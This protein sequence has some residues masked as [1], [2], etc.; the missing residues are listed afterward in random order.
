MAELGSEP[1]CGALFGRE[2]DLREPRFRVTQFS[3]PSSVWFISVIRSGNRQ[4]SRIPRHVT[5]TVT[6]ARLLI[7]RSSP[8]I[9]DERRDCLQ[10]NFPKTIQPFGVFTLTTNLGSAITDSTRELVTLRV[11]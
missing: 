3:V 9:F 8:Q 4:T 6:L 11:S 10:S 7:L 2:R 1:H 5:L